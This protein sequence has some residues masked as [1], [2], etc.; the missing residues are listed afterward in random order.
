LS[1]KIIAI[2]IDCG[3]SAFSTD[4]I[5]DACLLSV[6]HIWHCIHENYS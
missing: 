6:S 4:R 2:L 1:L 3:R 5:H